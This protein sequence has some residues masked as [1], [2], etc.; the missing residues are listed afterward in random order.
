MW[1]CLRSGECCQRVSHITMTWQERRELEAVAGTRRLEWR[2]AERPSLTAL[3]ARP[4]PFYSSQDGCT[5]Y[6]VRPYQC[7]RWMCGRTRLTEI[8]EDRPVP[9]RVLRSPELTADFKQLQDEAQPWALA[10]GW[11][12]EWS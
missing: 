1:E 6:A 7:R 10:H 12:P 5:V 9:L 11:K 3:K 2:A 4:C 8:I